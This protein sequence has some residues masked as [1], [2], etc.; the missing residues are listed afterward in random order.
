ML[1]GL[2]GAIAYGV[3]HDQI[4]VRICPEYL[5]EWHPPIIA[6][7]DPNTVALAWGVVATWW[8][9][10]IL[11]A[12]LAF[13]TTVGSWP[14]APWKWVV[15]SV[16][17]I[18]GTAAFSATVAGLIVSLGGFQANQEFFGPIFPPEDTVKWKA[19]LVV[20][21]IHTT[22]YIAAAVSAGIAGV[23]VLLLRSRLK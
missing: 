5:T 7:T 1:L 11:G 15:R 20:A 9:G 18:F 17:G 2:F 23:A 14:V 21:T 22:S 12:G 3:I 19:I 16:T 8:F 10:L 13:F 6:S 4:T